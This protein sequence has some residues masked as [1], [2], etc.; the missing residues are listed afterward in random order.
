MEV[1]VVGGGLAG[2]TAATLLGRAGLRVTLYDKVALGGRA[3]TS[4]HGGGKWNLG[5]HALYRGGVAKAVLEE[6]GVPL[7]GG[8]PSAAGNF[9]FL[10]GTLHALPGGLV[11]LL[12]TSLLPLSGKLELGR[13]LA[14]LPRLKR[15]C[16]EGLTVEAWLQRAVRSEAVRAVIRALFR[17]SCYANAPDRMSAPA[18]L[19]QLQLALRDNVLY[20][21]GGWQVLVQG[22]RAAAEGAGVRV[23]EGVKVEGVACDGGA[24]R[25]VRVAGGEMRPAD[26][27]VLAVP[28]HAAA[29]LSQDAELTA[30]AGRLTPIRA[31][32]LDL[33]LSRLPKPRGKFA[34]GIDRPLY[35]SVHS[36]VAKLGPEGTHVV[37][38][39]KYLSVEDKGAPALGELEALCDVMQ[40]GWREVT[41]ERRF[42]PE[43]HVTHAIVTLE[44]R[45]PVDAAQTRGLFVAGDWVGAEAML[46]DAAFASARE[47][48]ARI[49]AGAHTQ[50][51]A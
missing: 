32:S 10:D 44:G 33:T 3:T 8:V 41:L 23:V 1:T 39:A 25:G 24:V 48:S 45:P 50:A 34:L 14:G 17:V 35:F 2:L 49:L 22:L 12:S 6:L 5:P 29:A 11:S 37:H 9:A 16:V 13:L 27:V 18:A 21:D 43:L 19:T 15:S 42:L 46:A 28:P 31:A 7:I 51:A 38:A 20:L 26:R 30:W 36:L 4:E 40:P 47:V